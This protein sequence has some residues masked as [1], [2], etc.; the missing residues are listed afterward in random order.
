M[1]LHH[2]NSWRMWQQSGSGCTEPYGFQSGIRLGFYS[3]VNNWSRNSRCATVYLTKD[4]STSTCFLWGVV[5]RSASRPIWKHCSR[6][7][8]S[9]RCCTWWT[10]NNCKVRRWKLIILQRGVQK[11][12]GDQAWVDASNWLQSSKTWHMFDHC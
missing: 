8:Y 4:R 12:V 1:H 7:R 2:S 5:G 10:G 3:L 9:G 6:W 11:V